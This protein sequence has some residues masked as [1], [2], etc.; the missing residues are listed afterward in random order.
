MWTPVINESAELTLGALYIIHYSERK[1]EKER[2]LAD[3]RLGEGCRRGAE[4][5]DRK[6]ALSSMNHTILSGPSFLRFYDSAPLP[7]PPPS[8]FPLSK[9]SL[10][11]NLHH[12]RGR[13]RGVMDEESKHMTAK[14][15]ALYK[16]FNP[17]WVFSFP[18]CVLLGRGKNLRP[19]FLKS[20]LCTFRGKY[21]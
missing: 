12:W 7:L 16:S 9:L 10:F 3:G 11:L 6:K 15:L 2:Q 20:H 5:Y 19:H 4:S 13:G 18:Q 21:C 1:T 8:P 17:L 14:R